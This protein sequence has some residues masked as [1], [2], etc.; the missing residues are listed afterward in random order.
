MLNRQLL[1]NDFD[2]F[3][4]DAD[5]EDSQDRLDDLQKILKHAQHSLAQDLASIGH[6]AYHARLLKQMRD[7]KYLQFR[8]SA[9]F[10]KRKVRRLL[11]QRKFEIDR[12]NRDAGLSKNGTLH[13][14]NSRPFSNIDLVK[15]L[16]DHANEQIAKRRPAILR[17]I[18]QFNKDRDAM[19]ALLQSREGY[20]PLDAQLPLAIP[21]NGA[22]DL[23]V[24]SDIW[25]DTGLD[26]SSDDNESASPAWLCNEDIKIGIRG[27]LEVDRCY[28]ERARL[29][30]ESS[31][32]QEAWKEDYVHV[33]ESIHGKSIH[34]TLC[35]AFIQGRLQSLQR[36]LQMVHRPMAI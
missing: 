26:L 35:P 23:T 17:A 14:L 20:I 27:Q 22:W 12:R 3:D 21:T 11:Q 13:N 5:V 28:E 30:A 19:A 9:T 32:A 6:D 2:Q 4:R 15:N 36:K 24:D 10:Q 7:S 31:R 8:S 33:L 25:N 34:T 1:D 18:A 16:D 29:V